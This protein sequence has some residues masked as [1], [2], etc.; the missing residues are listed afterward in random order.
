[1]PPVSDVKNTDIFLVIMFVSG[2]VVIEVWDTDLPVWG[3]VL[4]LLICML[5]YFLYPALSSPV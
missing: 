4:A 1:V 5:P 2:V 3:F